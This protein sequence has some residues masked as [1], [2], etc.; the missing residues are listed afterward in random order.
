MEPELGLLLASVELHPFVMYCATPLF[1]TRQTGG[2]AE[3]DV[4]KV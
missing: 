1:Q 2:L 4:S 3:A